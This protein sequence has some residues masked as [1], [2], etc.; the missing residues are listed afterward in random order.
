[1]G[2]RYVSGAVLVLGVWGPSHSGQK[3]ASPRRRRSRTASASTVAPYLVSRNAEPARE[4]REAVKAA[5]VLGS[6]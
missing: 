4:M 2:K 1:M 5:A 6:C 3:E